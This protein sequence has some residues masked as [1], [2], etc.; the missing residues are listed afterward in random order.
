MLNC[1]ILSDWQGCSRDRITSALS[2]N[3]TMPVRMK[4]I[5]KDLNVSVV[6]VSKVLRNHSDISPAMKQRV[7]QRMKELNYQPN[8]TARS[9]VTGKTFMI[10]LIVPH[11]VHPFFAEV[12]KGL[13]KVIR[14]KG[15]SLVISSSEED[16]ELEIQEIDMPLARQV[17]ALVIASA[18]HT[19]EMF[20][21]IQDRKTPFV[22]VDRQLP[23]LSANYVG[24]DD[25]QIGRLATEHLIASGYRRIAHI[26][27]PEI[28]TGE[29]RFHGHHKAMDRL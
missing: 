13:S 1:S 15:Y 6:T 3:T 25:Q 19:G 17:D 27:G 16:P 23:G 14:E 20:Q 8:W 10:G 4:D 2:L 28:S 18:Q 11:L 24:V 22:L 26:R 12:A 29:A 9:L 5:A 7:L 21:R